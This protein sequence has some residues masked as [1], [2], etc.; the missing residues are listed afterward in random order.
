MS[1]I[2]GT[3]SLLGHGSWVTG[4]SWT[5]IGSQVSGSSVNPSGSKNR[6]PKISGPH[7]KMVSIF[8]KWVF[9]FDKYRDMALYLPIWHL[10]IVGIQACSSFLLPFRERYHEHRI[11][12]FRRLTNAGPCARHRRDQ[13]LI[14]HAY[15]N[16]LHEKG[17]VES[18]VKKEKEIGYGNVQDR[19]QPLRTQGCPA[20]G[21]GHVMYSIAQHK[22]N[23]CEYFARVH[24]VRA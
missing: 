12:V 3:Q 19:E 11:I 22:W 15:E 13:R 7:I 1:G 17:K 20:R 9:P 5:N 10:V 14:E 6:A 8:I 23:V 2:Q 21:Q 4:Q 18:C 16:R 24:R